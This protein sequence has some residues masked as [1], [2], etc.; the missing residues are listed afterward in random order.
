[1]I[2]ETKKAASAKAA[3]TNIEREKSYRHR[4]GQS[5]PN[6]KELLGALLLRLVA[7]QAE[8]DGW[9]LFEVLLGQ[10]CEIK[11]TVRVSI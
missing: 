8:P 7:G 4:D 6:L 3:K 10:Y 11:Q 2:A 5:S 1:M 9:V